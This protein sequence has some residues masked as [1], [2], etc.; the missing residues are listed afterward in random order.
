MV[1]K[2]FS[3]T[4]TVSSGENVEREVRRSVL[5]EMFPGNCPHRRVVGAKLKRW[6]QHGDA[7]LFAQGFQCS[8]ELFIGSDAPSH[9]HHTTAGLREGEVD[10]GNDGFDGGVLERRSEVGAVLRWK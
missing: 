8:A 6:D 7:P 5:L 9:G 1:F 2:A 3:V 10:L 4:A